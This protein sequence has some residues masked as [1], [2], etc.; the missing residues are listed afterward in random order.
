VAAWFFTLVAVGLLVVAI[1]AS[2]AGNG[3]GAIILGTTAFAGFFLAALFASGYQTIVR[4]GTREAGAYRGPSPLLVFGAVFAG[5]NVIASLVRLSGVG[6]S[7]SQAG[8]VLLSVG[9]IFVLYAA[10]VWLLVVREDALSW[11]AMGWPAFWGRAPRTVAEFSYGV[12]LAVPVVL[13]TLVFGSLLSVFLQVREPSLLPVPTTPA[14]WLVDLLVAVV[15]APL[16]EELFFRGFAQTAWA[17]DLGWRRALIRTAIFFAVVH[18]LSTTATDFSEA[19]RLVLLTGLV[20]VPVALALGWV[21]VRTRSIA[22][23]IG[24]HAAFNGVTLLLFAFIQAGGS[25]G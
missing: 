13:V 22:A 8:L 5:G 25:P 12:A 24:L 1:A 10:V 9:I 2:G 15:L 7:L 3:D 17:L 14:D 6:P 19:S 4:R 11:E 21:F 16:G 18:A 20:R 23:P